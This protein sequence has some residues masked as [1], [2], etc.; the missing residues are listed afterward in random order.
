MHVAQAP[1]GDQG[2][3]PVAVFE[4]YVCPVLQE[5]LHILLVASLN[6]QLQVGFAVVEAIRIEHFVQ[7]F[8]GQLEELTCLLRQVSGQKLAKDVQLV[9]AGFLDGFGNDFV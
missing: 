9:E 3:V 6:G 7:V 8:L 2:C 1:C 5:N 4:L